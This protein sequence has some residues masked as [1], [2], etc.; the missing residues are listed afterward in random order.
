MSDWGELWDT[1]DL[2]IAFEREHPHDPQ[3]WWLCPAGRHWGRF[4][5]AGVLPWC[6]LRGRVFVLLSLRSGLVEQGG[7]WSTLGGAM[8]GQEPPQVAAFRELHEETKL[9]VNLP[10]IG[11]SVHW[12][13][14]ARCGWGYTT[15]TA[16]VPARRRLPGASVRR[17][18]HA[19]E[20]AML[21][22]FPAGEVGSMDLHP[23]LR[24]VWPQLL[25]LAG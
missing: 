2:A 5:G 9:P 8:N 25:R 1:R 19:W 13:C 12:V 24:A 3:N 14:P 6:R 17:G 20:T 21:R 16:Q 23:G 7:V 22:W 15:F 18:P 4:G 10:D 11:G